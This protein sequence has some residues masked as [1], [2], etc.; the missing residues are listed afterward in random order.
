MMKVFL[1]YPGRDF[2]PSRSLP[3]N[4]EDLTQDLALNILFEAMAQGDDFL[5]QVARQV[6]LLPLDEMDTIVYRQEI[7]RDCLKY[8]DVI[9]QIYQIPLEFLERKRR[10]WLWISPSRSSPSLILSSARELLEASLDLLR[11]LRQIADQHSE[12]FASP[13]FQRFF[14]MIQQELDD[15]YLDVGSVSC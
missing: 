5:F 11:R 7:L 15:E 9:R 12:A 8:P 1:L 10:R 6:V 3:P 4:A 14:T 2:E 13:G